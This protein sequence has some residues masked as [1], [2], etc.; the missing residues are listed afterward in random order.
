MT[1]SVLTNTYYESAYLLA[2]KRIVAIDEMLEQYGLKIDHKKTRRIIM[3]VYSY[4][5]LSIRS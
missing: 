2:I 3:G 5:E 4:I 1:I